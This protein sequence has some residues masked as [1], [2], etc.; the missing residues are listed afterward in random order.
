M[1]TPKARRGQ[2]E[3]GAKVGAAEKKLVAGSRIRGTRSAHPGVVLVP[4]R[5]RH[6]SWT[7]RCE[8]PDTGKRVFIRLDPMGAGRNAQ[9]RRLWAVEKSRQIA[10]RKYE[11]ASGAPRATGTTVRDAVDRYFKDSHRL[12]EQT[13]KTY[14]KGTDR[15]LAWCEANRI[16]LADDLKLAQLVAFRAA[17]SSAPKREPFIGSKRGGKR[18]L[19]TARTASAVNVDIRSIKAV[20]RYLRS[21]GLTPRLSRDDIADG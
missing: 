19:E 8:D 16:Q 20:L 3:V 15:F 2:L 7:A 13:L 1:V 6:P 18:E 5:D 17:L 12:R 14:R 9:T 21:I 11:L 4:P 10:K